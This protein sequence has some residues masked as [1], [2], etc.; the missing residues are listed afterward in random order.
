MKERILVTGGAGYIGSILVPDLLT[1]GY[2]VTVVD[3]L[4]YKQNSLLNCCANKNFNFIKG[5]IC[6]EAL[7]KSLIQRFDII[8][9]LAAIVGAPACKINPTLTKLVN[10]DAHMAMVK[11][12]TP[13]QKVVFPCTNS[14]YGI[15]EPDAYCTVKNPYSN[16]YLNMEK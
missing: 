8:I 13:S 2:T 3:A 15:G 4:I 6:D 14:G 1:R 9:P 12:V 5:D 11:L 7:L 10:Y 16:P